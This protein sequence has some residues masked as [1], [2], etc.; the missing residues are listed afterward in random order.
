M[1]IP[2]AVAYGQVNH[3]PAWIVPN[4]REPIQQYT[5]DKVSYYELSYMNNVQDFPNIDTETK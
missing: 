4:C 5:F 2:A 3:H 1:M